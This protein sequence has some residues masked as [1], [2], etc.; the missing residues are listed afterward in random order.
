MRGARNA[1]I[2]SPPRWVASNKPERGPSP[3]YCPGN[4]GVPNWAQIEHAYNPA[5]N[6]Q[7]MTQAHFLLR[8]R[9]MRLAI[10]PWYRLGRNPARKV[11]P[12]PA[13]TVQGRGKP[14]ARGAQRVR[15]AG[16][17]RPPNTLSFRAGGG[18]EGFVRAGERP[19]RPRVT[20][21]CSAIRQL[22]N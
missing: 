7:E 4:A 6:T 9:A 8:Q 1:A 12:R 16:A 14:G 3:M 5:M 20:E 22:F 2:V 17:A 21:Q 15:A 19:M 10:A 13:R 18:G 11:H